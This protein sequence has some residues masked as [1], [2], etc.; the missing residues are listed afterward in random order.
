MKEILYTDF[1]GL[2]DLISKMFGNN[3]LIQKAVKRSNLY[4]FWSKTVGAPYDKKSKPYGM[5]GAHTMIIACESAVVAQELTL[6]KKE[7]IKKLAPYTKS[8]RI[9]LR[10]IKFD[11]KR[12][13]PT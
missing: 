9:D 5:M 3:A 13:Q 2:D 7:I 1:E 10:D 12:W 11:I 8:L 4:K 6:R